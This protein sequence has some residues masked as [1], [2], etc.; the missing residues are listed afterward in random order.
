MRVLIIGDGLV[1]GSTGVNWVKRLAQKHPD[2]QIEN[3]GINGE[4]I[5]KISCRLRKKLLSANQYDTIVLLAGAND[6]LLP[7]LK[8]KGWFFRRAYKRLL[9]TNRPL[10]EVGDF[11]AKLAETI[12]LIKTRTN[13]NI[14]L[15][16]ISCLS[17]DLQ[18]PLNK[19]RQQFNRVI[20]DL[21]QENGCKLADAAALCD[22]CLITL[23]TKD[24]FLQNFLN[25][26]CLDKW[27][28]LVPGR[29]DVISKKRQLHL[30]I[31]GVHVNSLGARF[32]MEEIERQIGQDK[33]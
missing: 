32:Y 27:Q 19:N 12:R 6:I 28:S 33:R 1:K 13:A 21:A 9:D 2:W 25:T 7:E 10:R 18:S 23:R 24:Y 17:E 31:D 22:G 4:T 15:V 29:A 8:H 20:R 5:T 14:V 3:A 16:T 26:F 11:A 30:T